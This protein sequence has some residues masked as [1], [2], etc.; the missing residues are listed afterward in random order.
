LC[1]VILIIIITFILKQFRSNGHEVIV[2]CFQQ[3]IT[4]PPQIGSIITVQHNGF[5]QSG[6]LRYPFY[7][8]QRNDLSWNKITQTSRNLVIILFI[9]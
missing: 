6:V 9:Y 4:N 2:G 5:Y 7:W 3:I 8:K 1:T